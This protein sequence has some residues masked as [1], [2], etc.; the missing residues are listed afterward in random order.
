MILF[1]SGLAWP[2]KVEPELVLKDKEPG[3][4]LTYWEIH[5]NLERR[6]WKRFRRHSRRRREVEIKK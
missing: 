5:A 3:V 1:F 4:M 6:T 2:R